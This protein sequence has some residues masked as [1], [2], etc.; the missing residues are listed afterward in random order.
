LVFTGNPHA[1]EVAGLKDNQRLTEFDLQVKVPT[2]MIFGGSR[3][4]AP[5]N[6]VVVQALPHLSQ[7]DYQVLFVTGKVHYEQ[8]LAQI[9]PHQLAA[10]LKIVPYIDDMP[11]ILPDVSLVVG[12]SGAT[13]IAEL[14]ALGVPCIFIPSP[15]VTHDHQTKNAQALVKKQAAL[16]IAEKQLTSD[17]LVKMID[18]VLSNHALQQQLAQNARKLGVV[19]ASDR[20]I[21]VLEDLISTV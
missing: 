18:E 13:S 7:K 9:K 21:T 5:I 12:R 11:A 17:K 14:T 10:N 20:L 16:M 1:Q 15:Y 2:V 19:D 6:R 4:A 8:V 3:G